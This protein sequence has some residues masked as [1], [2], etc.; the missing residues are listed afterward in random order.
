[1]KVPEWKQTYGTPVLPTFWRGYDGDELSFKEITLAPS[2]CTTLRITKF[3]MYD[4][5]KYQF[6]FNRFIL[7]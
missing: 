1:M 7:K 3:P 2:G 5:K 4:G 6:Y